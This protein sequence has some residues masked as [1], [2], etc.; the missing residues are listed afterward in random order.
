MCPHIQQQGPRVAETGA[1]NQAVPVQHARDRCA[2]IAYAQVGQEATQRLSFLT[3]VGGATDPVN[4][5]LH[6]WL[7][8]NNVPPPSNNDLQNDLDRVQDCGP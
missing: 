3:A 5:S 8:L 2:G 4:T 7:Y 6:V 1:P